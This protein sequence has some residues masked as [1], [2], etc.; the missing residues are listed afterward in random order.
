VGVA[1]VIGE[2]SK[3]EG[4]ALAGAFVIVAEDADEVRRACSALPEQTSLVVLTKR[5]ATAFAEA[6]PGTQVL[7]AVM[8]S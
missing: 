8:P 3:V 6:T 1:V 7:T 4:F 5:A 2:A